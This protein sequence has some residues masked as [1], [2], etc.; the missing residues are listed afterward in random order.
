MYMPTQTPSSNGTFAQIN[1]KVDKINRAKMP[2]ETLQELIRYQTLI[3]GAAEAHWA[4]KHPGEEIPDAIARAVELSLAKIEDGSAIS[5]L[6]RPMDTG[7]DDDVDAGR[8]AV[9]ELI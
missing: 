2:L 9:D 4:E 7:Y 6:E 5:V 8:H 3:A 1:I